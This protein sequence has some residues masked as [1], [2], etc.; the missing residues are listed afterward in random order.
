MQWQLA[1]L[2]SSFGILL[3]LFLEKSVVLQIGWLFY[4]LSGLQPSDVMWGSIYGGGTKQL[5]RVTTSAPA[6]GHASFTTSTENPSSSQPPGSPSATTAMM[7][8]AK[9]RVRLHIK[10]LQNIGSPAAVGGGL[11]PL[12]ELLSK[13]SYLLK[14]HTKTISFTRISSSKHSKRKHFE[15]NRVAE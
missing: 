11:A 5:V 3:S 8:V 12:G 6:S 10:L 7:D 14:V 13:F 15:N 2:T 1:T 4:S 9:Q